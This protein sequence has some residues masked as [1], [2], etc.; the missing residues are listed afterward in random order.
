LGNSNSSRSDRRLLSLAAFAPRTATDKLRV[1][2]P[3]EVILGLFGEY[4]KP[5]E[6]V[7]SGGLVHLL[8][9]LHF[10]AAA[11]RIALSRVVARR[12][13]TPSRTG[14]YV[15]YTISPRLELVHEEA[16]HQTFSISI[17]AVWDGNWTVV[18]YSIPETLRL[19]RA[20]L[21]RWLSF[22]GFES[23]QDGTWIA[24]G[25]RERDVVSLSRE[26]GLDDHVITFIARLSKARTP[27]SLVGQVWN[28]D[29]LR[30][31]YDMLA[32][33]FAPYARKG[34]QSKISLR[35]SFIVRTRAIEMFRSTV[36]QDPR[37]PD[38]VL[39]MKWKRAEA[40]KSFDVLQR[41][42][43]PA[44]GRYFRER[45]MPDSVGKK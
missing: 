23:L 12:L 35:E 17:D 38:S 22:R 44:A 15:F 25:D 7:W 37:L 31:A 8:Q 42:L 18:W 4:V 39:G 30:L 36:S 32:R 41:N 33:E 28:L 43:A 45:A 3:Q 40:L 16:R 1:L 13:L 6:K 29:A 26:L 27:R 11:S 5:R 34:S 9:D 10:S 14:K 21:S 20:R 24:P 2:Q 19:K